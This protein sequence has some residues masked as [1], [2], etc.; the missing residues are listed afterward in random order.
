MAMCVD[1]FNFLTISHQDR[2]EEL[3][4]R[5]EQEQEEKTMIKTY[6]EGGDVLK[7]LVQSNLQHNKAT[8][9]NH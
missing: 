2:A 9:L 8:I 4:N 6:V 5:A 3:E 7:N 1:C